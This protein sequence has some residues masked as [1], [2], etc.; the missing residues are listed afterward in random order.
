VLL[1]KFAST[2]FCRFVGTHWR[3][4]LVSGLRL[5]TFMIANLLVW[6]QSSSWTRHTVDTGGGKVSKVQVHNSVAWSP[7]VI[8]SLVSSGAAHPREGSNSS[9]W[10]AAHADLKNKIVG[11]ALVRPLFSAGVGRLLTP[12]QREVFNFWLRFLG[13]AHPLV[14]FE[15]V[16]VAR[17][18]IPQSGHV[19]SSVPNYA[20]DMRRSKNLVFLLT[21]A[22][23][24][25]LW[26]CVAQSGVAMAEI[27]RG[28]AAE[29][30][31]TAVVAQ[32]PTTTFSL[33]AP[34][35][36]L[37]SAGIWRSHAYPV[38]I[39]DSAESKRIRRWVG[40]SSLRQLLTN[41]EVE[42]VDTDEGHDADATSLWAVR[43]ESAQIWADML[44]QYAAGGRPSTADARD[45][46]LFHVRLLQR[47]HDKSLMQAAQYTNNAFTVEHLINCVVFSGFLKFVA[48]CKSAMLI[49]VR[50]ACGSQMADYFHDQIVQNRALPEQSFL[51]TPHWLVCVATEA[52]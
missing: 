8:A 15:V 31:I 36:L 45:E 9:H 30:G 1:D 39:G 41:M 10:A 43:P 29:L 6:L 50:A 42:A 44:R 52:D 18:L 32:A 49:G 23:G 14:F 27:A 28:W 7:F 24:D 47:F 38:P 2:T 40:S 5:P 34:H 35:A 21:R 13:T 11:L 4:H 37:L 16:K 26:S 19:D 17:F 3:G 25:R 51:Y 48:D 46:V 22:S 33:P 12:T 20:T